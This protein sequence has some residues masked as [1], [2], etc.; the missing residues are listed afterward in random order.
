MKNLFIASIC[1][2]LVVFSSSAYSQD[3]ALKPYQ[4][5]D[6]ATII[7][8]AKDKPMAVHFWG[9]TCPPCVK[10]MPQWGS[11]LAEDKDV[12]V[13]FI[14]VDD[15][16]PEMMRKMLDQAKLGKADNYY[17]AGQFDERMRY[18]V[19]PKWRGETPITIFI[20]KNGNKKITVGSVSFPV[21]R[22]W[23]KANS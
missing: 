23:F 20:D 5:G 2:L 17:I 21:V 18:E 7:G 8:S 22:K 14:Q 19:D 13:V 15:V 10:E 6:W 16:P 9:V 3:A 1:A 12:K 11:F 4:K